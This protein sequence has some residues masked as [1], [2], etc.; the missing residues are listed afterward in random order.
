MTEYQIVPMARR[1]IAAIAALETLC[2]SDPWSEAA[3]M[4]ELENPLSLWLVAETA[5]GGVLG[6]VGS[7][8]V[9]PEADMMNIAVAP[10]A[11]RQG[12]AEALVTA[13]VSALKEE[14]V[15]SLTLEVRVSNAPARALYEKLGFVPVGLRKN[16]YFHPKE[17]A[18]ILRKDWNT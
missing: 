1:H 17:D 18:C 3:I 15:A 16:Y 14:H 13:L 5:D 6:Y 9:P 11:R 7:Q 4:P 8:R 10:E 2:F 12:I